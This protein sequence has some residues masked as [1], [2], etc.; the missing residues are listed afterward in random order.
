MRPLPLIVC[1]R[2]AAVSD[3]RAVLEEAIA[4][5]PDDVSNYMA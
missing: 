2:G 3:L 4:S 5:D 1:V